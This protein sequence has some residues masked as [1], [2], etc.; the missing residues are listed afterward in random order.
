[1]TS[2]TMPNQKPGSNDRRARPPGRLIDE[3]VA[4][5]RR[6]QPERDTDEGRND[7][8]QRRKFERRRKRLGEVRRDGIA[9]EDSRAEITMRQPVQIEEKL[10]VDRQIEPQ[11]CP[12]RRIGGGIGE[13]ADDRANRI[14]G[15]D[16]ADHEGHT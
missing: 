5:Q 14:G 9:G 1:M 6:H 15:Q 2:P 8:R 13:L 3:A 11:A 7:Y 10:L 16:A 12:H 4:K